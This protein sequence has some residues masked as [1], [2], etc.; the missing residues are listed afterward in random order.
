MNVRLDGNK[1]SRIVMMALV[2]AF[3]AAAPGQTGQYQQLEPKVIENRLQQYSGS[4]PVREATLRKIFRE[5]GCTGERLKEQAVLDSMAPNLVCTLPGTGE[6]VIIVGAHFDHVAP[7]DG[8]V[9]NWSGASLLPSLFQSLSSKPR[10]HTFV[11]ISFT[12]E[13]KGFVGSQ[14]YV[15]GLGR[16]EIARIRAMVDVDTIGLGPTEIWVSNSDPILVKNLIDVAASLKLPIRGMNVDGVGDSDSRTFKAR[17]IPTI[18]LH[19]VTNDT[20]RIL[21]TRKDSYSAI[22]PDSYY[23]SYRL[24]SAYLAALDTALLQ[25]H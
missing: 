11:F 10:N 16:E 5:A 9:D 25:R 2:L 3:S 23:E 15:A 18:T 12:D 1:L 6:G 20:V 14:S 13:E 17:K 19:S 21:H 7:G 4:D 8:V 22:K 24:I